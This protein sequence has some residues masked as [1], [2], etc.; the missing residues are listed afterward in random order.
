[1]GNSIERVSVILDVDAQVSKATSNI[2]SIGKMFDGFGGKKGSQL[3]DIL[4]DIN[5]EYQKLA[6]ESGKAMNKLGDFSKAEKSM[7]KVNQLFGKLGKELENIDKMSDEDLSKLFPPEVVERIK[8]ASD[9]MK[10]YNDYMADSEK[11][12]GAIGQVKKQLEDQEKVLKRNIETLKELQKIQKGEGSKQVVTSA[13]KNSAQIDLNKK[14]AEI[15]AYSKEMEKAQQAIE[16]FRKESSDLFANGD[17]VGN[18]KFDKLNQELK[19]AKTNFERVSNEADELRDNMNNMVLD[20]DLKADIE[21]TE[22]ALRESQDAVE[23]LEKS[24]DKVKTTEMQ[25]GFELA[26]KQLQD[27]AGID[28]DNLLQIEDIITLFKRFEREGLEGVKQG[29]VEVKE[30]M[31]DLGTANKETGDNIKRTKEENDQLNKSFGEI[32][33]IKNRITEFF[34]LDNAIQLVRQGI[35]KT[36]ETIKELDKAMAETAVVTDFSVGDMWDA[37]PKYTKAAN[38]L[39]TTTLGAY[40][41]MTLFYQQGLDTNE[42]FEVGTETM[43]MARIAGLDYAEATNL[44]TAAL[45]GFNMELNETSAQRVND[46]YSE[47]A[48]ITAADTE[49]IATAMTKTASIAKSANMEFET[50][51]AFLSQ[52][53]ETTREPAE[54]AGTAMKTI[55][56]RFTEMKKATSDIINVD[57]EEVNVNKVEEALRSA[58]V[59][60]RDLNGEFRDTDD[61][62]LELASKWD[63]LDIMTQRYI[64]TMAAGSRQQSRF[65]AMMQDYD[66][67]IE[68]IDAAYNSSGAS[69]AQFAKTQETLESKLNKLKNAWDEFLMGIA[70]SKL[71]KGFVDI[72]TQLLNI[73]N[74]LT[75]NS[76]FA[77]LTV[78][79][80]TLLGGKIISDKIFG[81]VENSIVTKLLKPLKKATPVIDNIKD[82]LSGLGTG[83]WWSQIKGG[84]S[85]FVSGASSAIAALTPILPLLAA[86]AALLITIGAAWYFS[87]EQVETR[88]LKEAQELAASL[89]EGLEDAREAVATI[90]SDKSGLETLKNELKDLVAG[91]DEWRLK[92]LEVQAEESKL[93]GK[94]NL[95]NIEGAVQVDQYG[96]Q[97]ITSSGW[98]YVEKRQ[99]EAVSRQ[100][101]ASQIANA[102]VNRQQF[103]LE[104]VQRTEAAEDESAGKTDDVLGK[105][106]GAI[107]GTGLGVAGGLTGMGLA[108]GGTVGTS[109]IATAIAG[110]A[111][112]AVSG[113]VVPIIGTV[114]GAIGGLAAGAAVG[115]GV[116]ELIEEASHDEEYQKTT[117]Q[118][119]QEERIANQQQTLAY[120][121]AFKSSM[122]NNDDFSLYSAEELDAVATLSA[123]NIDKYIE[124]EEKAIGIGDNNPFTLNGA[125]KDEIKDWAENYKGYTYK[126]D[127]VYDAQGKEVDISDNEAIAKELATFRAMERTEEV[128]KTAAAHLKTGGEAVKSL[129]KD[130][131]G[132]DFAKLMSGDSTANYALVDKMQEEGTADDIASKILE[133]N[134]GRE[135]ELI[136][137]LTGYTQEEVEKGLKK[138][139]NDYTKYLSSIL[140]EKAKE[141]DQNQQYMK[142]DFYEEIAKTGVVIDSATVEIDSS[143]TSLPEGVNAA[144]LQFS[145]GFNIQKGLSIFEQLDAA[146]VKSVTNI[147]Q[148]LRESFGKAG[149]GGQKFIES[150]SGMNLDQVKTTISYLD[151]VDFSNPIQGAAAFRKALEM[152]GK[153][154]EVGKLITELQGISDNEYDLGSQFDFLYSSGVFENL[155]EPMAELIEENGK[156]TA[157]NVLELADASEELALFL[158]NDK[159]SADGLATALTLVATK[160]PDAMQGITS[161]TLAAISSTQTLSTTYENMIASIEGFKPAV[162][163]MSGI[164]FTNQ[165]LEKMKEMID[166]GEYGNAQLQSYLKYFYGDKAGKTQTDIDKQYQDLVKWSKNEG[167]DFWTEAQQKGVL[168]TGDTF[169]TTFKTGNLGTMDIE[170]GLTTDQALKNIQQKMGLTEEA[171]TN[172]LAVLT[173]HSVELSEKLQANDAAAAAQTLYEERLAELTEAKADTSVVAFGDAELQLLAEKYGRTVEQI[174]DEIKTAAGTK[175]EV[176]FAPS[177][178]DTEGRPLTGEAL[179]EKL[180]GETQNGNIALEDLIVKVDVDGEETIDYLETKELMLDVGLNEEQATEAINQFLKNTQNEKGENTFEFSAE[181]KIIPKAVTAEEAN[182]WAS[183]AVT[184]VEESTVQVFADTLANLSYAATGKKLAKDVKEEIEKATFNVSLQPKIKEFKSKISAAITEGSATSGTWYVSFYKDGSDG[185]PKDQIGMTGEEGIEIVQ[186]KDGT[187]RLVGVG[188]PELTSLKKGDKVYTA[189]ETKKILKGKTSSKTFPAYAKGTSG[190]G[191][192]GGSTKKELTFSEKVADWFLTLI[193][194]AKNSQNEKDKENKKQAQDN[195]KPNNKKPTT[196]DTK[197]TTTNNTKP[198]TTTKKTTTTTNNKSNT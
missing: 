188:G 107:L 69:A 78:A 185:I 181:G 160:G 17:P 153:D 152:E 186:S 196:N 51:A 27:M 25:K 28:L 59:A 108:L 24:L 143:S 129:G 192:S 76:G 97:T 36:F 178:V 170:E 62:F 102:A 136:A 168:G 121:N 94:Y 105:G 134:K 43:K 177:F 4:Q 90:A 174:K 140:Q 163:T 161:A 7:Q 77:K 2:S 162:D 46:V 74:K 112:G 190:G 154:S 47:L 133:G 91:T 70:D 166:S 50:T 14:I 184:Q 52:I 189:E 150:L 159:I 66:R 131:T 176:V 40:E 180:N 148:S 187:A 156:L 132:S 16:D 126:D 113:S 30:K 45:R 142:E 155:S 175:T 158:E 12:K 26:K 37:L 194:K 39:G 8:A 171:A 72:L 53:I 130:I 3:R 86:V 135:A 123:A 193:A 147:S 124:E 54:T 120:K 41:T 116:N 55:I 49:E 128:A 73:I 197:P 183:S 63:N 141:T 29:L 18:A 198:T 84:M 179:I 191:L 144:A 65:L 165:S 146:S 100:L 22:K 1:M 119:A 23:D 44:M 104:K 5:T 13:E 149:M 95:G 34:K 139:D 31:K 75:G 172:Y 173:S 42:V 82:K 122:S 33:G 167:R 89:A 157:D 81:N 87:D 164:D 15:R 56:A 21:K 67:T 92:L 115:F 96:N 11:A 60:L 101:T 114:V 71:V 19:E 117:D 20:K 68:L 110:M 88:K 58:G 32:Q 83:S 111:Y 151:G 10:T 169:S 145:D 48:A 38:E 106:I 137:S 98:D 103:E 99:S 9:A 57:G 93:I 118:I 182:E 6:D 85:N 79:L 138:N 80:G 35:Q 64:A 61:V 195:T 109:A 125:N 127:K